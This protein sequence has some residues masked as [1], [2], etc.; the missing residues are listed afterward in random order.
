MS[1]GND[2]GGGFSRPPYIGHLTEGDWS[3][4]RHGPARNGVPFGFRV[5]NAPAVRTSTLHP[6][7]RIQLAIV[8]FATVME[9]RSRAIGRHF[10]F[11]NRLPRQ[12]VLPSRLRQISFFVFH[13]APEGLESQTS[14]PEVRSV[15][16]S[17]VRKSG[18]TRKTKK[19]ASSTPYGAGRML[20]RAA[21]TCSVVQP[22]GSLPPPS[23]PTTAPRHAILRAVTV[24]ESRNQIRAVPCHRPLPDGRLAC[25]V[26]TDHREPSAIGTHGRPPKICLQ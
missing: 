23:L 8:A 18:Q 22:A 10:T 17:L 14:I 9:S 16:S 26:G 24:V 1:R 20:V 12:N 4:A 25:F 6:S 21:F 3:L 7:H 15:R 19:P 5:Q 2:S 13:G 11:Q